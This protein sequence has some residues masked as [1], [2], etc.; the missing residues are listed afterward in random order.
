MKY[1]GPVGSIVADGRFRGTKIAGNKRIFLITDNDEPFGSTS[2]R[3]PARTVY[4]VRTGKSLS[5]LG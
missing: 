5:A 4:T 1:Y 2:N 3:A